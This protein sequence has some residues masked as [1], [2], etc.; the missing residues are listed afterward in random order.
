VFAKNYNAER[1]LTGSVPR[2]TTR[3]KTN[4]EAT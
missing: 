3:P 1:S 2:L 4:D